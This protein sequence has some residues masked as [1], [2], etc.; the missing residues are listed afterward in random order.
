MMEY[1]EITCVC[2]KTHS[3]PEK[4]LPEILVCKRCGKQI[5]TKDNLSNSATEKLFRF[6]NFMVI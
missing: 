1:V 3:V 2:G 6:H 4:Y 5:N